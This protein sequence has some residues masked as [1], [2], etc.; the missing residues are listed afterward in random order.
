MLHPLLG[1]RDVSMTFDRREVLSDVNLTVNSGDFMVITGPNGGGKTTMLKIILGLL[2]PTSGKV[3][4]FREG[5][6]KAVKIGYLPQKNMIDSHFPV[7]VREVVA[8]GL[9]SSGRA[10]RQTKDEKVREMISA[11]GLERHADSPIGALSGGQLQRTLLGRALVSKPELLVMDEPLSY[12]DKRFESRLYDI[13]KEVS[14]DTTVIVVSHELTH[15]AHIA[16]RHVLVDT[17]VKECHA[18]H[19]FVTSLC[20]EC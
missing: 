6:R 5:G 4:Y 20:D 17:T 18:S 19:H 1:L 15:L 7:L 14:K 8:M 16:N 2:R 11:M 13:L 9:L 3:E 10:D 12:I